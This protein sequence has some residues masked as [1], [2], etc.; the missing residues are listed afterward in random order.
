MVIYFLYYPFLGNVC[1]NRAFISFAI[2]PVQH[3]ASRNQQSQSL[4]KAA[5][6][7]ETFIDNSPLKDQ[8]EN[9]TGVKMPGEIGCDTVGTKYIIMHNVLRVDCIT[10]APVI[11]F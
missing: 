7:G 6:L 4:L 8:V 1:D 9:Q 5:T 3:A 2:K 11:L 10:V